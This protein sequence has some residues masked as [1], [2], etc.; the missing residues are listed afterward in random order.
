MMGETG[1]SIGGEKKKTGKRVNYPWITGPVFSGRVGL[2]VPSAAPL[3][4][5]FFFLHP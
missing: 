3:N 1:A 2:I 5:F 4:P